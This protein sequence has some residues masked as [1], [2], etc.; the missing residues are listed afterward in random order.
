MDHGASHDTP[1]QTFKWPVDGWLRGYKLEVIDKDGNEL[2]R[3]LMH[4]LIVVNYDRR[5]L[6][7]QAAERLFGTGTESED[8]SVP[9]TIGVP[10]KNGMTIGF[11]VAWHNDTGK[12]LDG[13]QLR[14]TMEY[15][16][17]NQNP[18]PLD[19]LPLYMDVNLTVGGT[20]TFD[21]PPG[22]STKSYEFTI[23]VGGRII[24]YGGHLHDYGTMVRLEDASNGKELAKVTATRD[25]KGNVLKVSRSLPGIKGAGIKLKANHP[26]R[27]IAYYD[28]PTGEVIKNGAMG[29]MSGLF[30][31]DDISKWPAIDLSNPTFQKDMASLEM[32]GMDMGEGEHDHGAHEHSGSDHN[33]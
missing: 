32:R 15:L 2:P 4:H 5:Q 20:N 10:L 33:E 12:D 13:V 24:G 1:V 26:Y 17:K 18:R 3:R 7:Y 22:K 27:V 6:L 11:Y 23:P 30:A 21:V 28:N 29:H 25:E 16:P 14:M 9:A 31:P 19:V 8:A